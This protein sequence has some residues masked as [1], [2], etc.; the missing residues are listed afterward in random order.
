MGL[1]MYAWAVPQEWAGNKDTDYQPDAD[2]ET[3]EIFYWCKFNHLH[4]WMERLYRS[5]GGENVSFNCVTVRLTPE[6]LDKLVYDFAAGKVGATE[7]LFF[8]SDTLYPEDVQS[9][10]TFVAKAKQAIADGKAVFYDSWW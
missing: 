5:K 4:G 1:D 9:V 8:G 6:D 3:E 7:G 10:Q 2:R